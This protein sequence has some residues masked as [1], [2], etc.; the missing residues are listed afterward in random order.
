MTV[1]DKGSGGHQITMPPLACTSRVYKA[2]LPLLELRS[3]IGTTPMGSDLSACD[4][5]RSAGPCRAEGEPGAALECAHRGGHG[6]G[7]L[8][9]GRLTRIGRLLRIRGT[10]KPQ[11]HDLSWAPGFGKGASEPE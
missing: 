3:R 1:S 6:A 4:H 10:S 11:S 5:A 8:C 2:V 9:W 7:H